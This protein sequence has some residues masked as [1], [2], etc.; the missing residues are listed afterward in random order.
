MKRPQLVFFQDRTN[1]YSV[2]LCVALICLSPPGPLRASKLQ[3]S[4]GGADCSDSAES[5]K[6]PV[7]FIS[8]NNGCYTFACEYGAATQHNV[9]TRDES[10]IKTLLQMGK[11]SGN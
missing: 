9:H 3:S 5:C 8:K 4:G 6:K 1:I 7:K 11:E 2:L 10:N